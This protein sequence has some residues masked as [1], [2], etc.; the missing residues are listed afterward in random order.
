MVRG[1][2]FEVA[3]RLRIM[4]ALPLSGPG[5]YSKPA[6]PLDL[7][8]GDLVQVRAKQE[9]VSTLTQGDTFAGCRS[10]AKWSR[11]AVGRI[12]SRTVFS[13]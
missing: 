6:E 11:F 1:F 7:Q 13:A 12:A 4:K 2:F 5:T 9:I 8:P 10:T 3:D